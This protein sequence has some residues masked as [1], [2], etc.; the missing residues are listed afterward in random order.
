M[1]TTPKSEG[2]NAP[3]QQSGEDVENLSRDAN[4]ST[5]KKVEPDDDVRPKP[6]HTVEQTLGKPGEGS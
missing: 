2:S 6:G 1:P 5:Y 4:D 3:S